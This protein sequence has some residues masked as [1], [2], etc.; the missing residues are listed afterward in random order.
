MLTQKKYRVGYVD[1]ENFL[2]WVLLTQ[3]N[4]KLG[5]FNLGYVDITKFSTCVM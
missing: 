4:I 5:Y 2:S 3:Q 1:L